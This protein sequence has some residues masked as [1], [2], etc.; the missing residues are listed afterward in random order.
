MVNELVIKM[1]VYGDAKAKELLYIPSMSFM[2]QPSGIGSTIY[3]PSNV[4][5]T[6][7]DL[8]AAGD[9]A[10]GSLIKNKDLLLVFLKPGAIKEAIENALS[11][12]DTPAKDSKESNDNALDNAELVLSLIFS[13]DAKLML[14]NKMFT[15][16]DYNVATIKNNIE[17]KQ[18]IIATINVTVGL[19]VNAGF[20]GKQR[21]TCKMK[22]DNLRQS[23]I[24]LFGYDIGEARAKVSKKQIDLQPFSL[25][26]EMRKKR[27]TKRRLKR[28]QYPMYMPP[29]MPGYA[30]YPGYPQYPVIAPPPGA[31]PKRPARPING[32]R[33]LK[34]KS[35]T[36]KR[37]R[38]K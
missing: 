38:V 27:K 4:R 36:H 12:G 31:K 19:S 26:D 20:V 16:Y 5:L 9:Y 37:R 14:K 30:M 18:R 2:T 25:K 32:G 3:I 35:K 8:K 17:K 7:R 24:Q 15:V 22:R 33:K 23:L 1:N 28:G 34:M 6:R 11:R 10:P 21:Y 29:Y 13:R